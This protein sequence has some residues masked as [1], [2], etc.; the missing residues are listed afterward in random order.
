LQPN[1]F[2]A[3]LAV[4]P[5][6][7]AAFAVLTVKLIER[8]NGEIKLREDLYGRR[9]RALGYD[10]EEVWVMGEMWAMVGACEDEAREAA[11]RYAKGIQ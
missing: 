2:W 4:M 5:L 6:V 3:A 9:A 8:R 11:K 1:D 7:G 10:P